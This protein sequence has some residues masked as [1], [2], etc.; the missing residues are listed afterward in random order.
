MCS[1]SSGKHIDIAALTKGA[2]N[3]DNKIGLVTSKAAREGISNLQRPLLV[4]GKFKPGAP[5]YYCDVNR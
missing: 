5:G 2:T 4:A 3:Q 1:F